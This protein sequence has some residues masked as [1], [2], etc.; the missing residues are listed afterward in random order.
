MPMK[1]I[2]R[3]AGRPLLMTASGADTLARRA[4]ALD[5]HVMTR[6]RS[7]IANPLGAL[8]RVGKADPES[9][10]IVEPL[11]KPAKPQGYAPR[12]A[13]APSAEG[14]GY[15]ICDGIAC[16]NVTGPLMDRGFEACGE[17]FWGY[18]L[19]NDAVR[20]A[21]ADASVGGVF[22]RMESPGG[23]VAAGLEETARTMR[24][25]REASGP[26][27][28]PIWV[29]ADMAASA[30]YWIAAQAD[31]I[32]ASPVSLV[33]S[34]GAVIVHYDTSAA[35]A[36]HGVKVTGIQF[37]A[38][39]TDGAEWKPLDEAAR[40]DLQAE[41]D[42]CGRRFVADVARGR[43]LMS[44][45]AS[46]DTQAAIYMALHDEPQRSGIA[47]GLVDAI[48]TERNAFAQLKAHV[49]KRTVA[50]VVAAAPVTSPVRAP[51]HG[52]TT[53]LPGASAQEPAM[54]RN[55]KAMSRVTAMTPDEKVAKIEEIIGN[56]DLAPEDKLTLIDGVMEEGETA[57]TEAAEGETPETTDAAA[58][59][60]EV[61]PTDPEEE[62][63]APAAKSKAEG[64]EVPS[65]EEEPQKEPADPVAK[66]K[67]ILDLPEAKGREG[68]AKELAFSG[69]TVKAARA[70]L[71]A[72]PV[73]TASRLAS[74]PDPKLGTGASAPRKPQTDDEKAAAFIAASHAAA[75]GKK[76]A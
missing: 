48:A 41:I 6:P 4:M 43:P 60:E 64:E 75:T 72:A 39:K 40:A 51:A 42:Q 69:L 26:S 37:G 55:H 68:L 34:I 2:A 23:V 74:V 44:A 5:A 52:K 25:L 16:M 1:T 50:P 65:P 59:G 10:M 46:I 3:Y 61:A 33:G 58:E 13:S 63:P 29:Y 71:K 14:L 45:D 53:T 7:W 18:D 24:E 28:K 35:N 57:E 47:I 19:I 11:I 21:M 17:V 15:A 8:A 32:V 27:G 49:A 73:A 36:A 76:V 22:I 20:E 70:A 12:Y 38:K 66:A 56:G 9:D 62:K 30:A 31:R 54:R 67:A